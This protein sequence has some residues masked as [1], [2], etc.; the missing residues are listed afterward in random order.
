MACI[1]TSNIAK[2]CLDSVG[3]IKQFWIYKTDDIDQTA[4]TVDADNSITLLA[5]VASPSSATPI[6]SYEVYSE[7]SIAEAT[8]ETSKENGST[9]WNHTVEFPINKMTQAHREEIKVLTVMNVGVI[10]LDNNGTYWLYGY[11]NGLTNNGSKSSTGTVLGDKN[12]YTIAMA[13]NEPADAVEIDYSAF[14]ALINP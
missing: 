10:A 2:G 13:G 9:F 14:S 6:Y 7:V 1:L 3:G 5:A 12:G 11:E 8:S 4:T